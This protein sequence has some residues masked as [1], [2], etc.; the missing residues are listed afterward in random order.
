MDINLAV[1]IIDVLMNVNG[2]TKAVVIIVI[3]MDKA[4]RMTDVLKR[5]TT[6]VVSRKHTKLLLRH[7]LVILPAKKRVIH[8]LLPERMYLIMETTQTDQTVL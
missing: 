8:L 4:N 6:L 2:T 5:V 3:D 1:M 7:S